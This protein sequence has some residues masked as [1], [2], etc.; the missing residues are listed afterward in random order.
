VAGRAA[1]KPKAKKKVAAKSAVAK[2]KV[3][4]KPR[5]KKTVAGGD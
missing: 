1:A 5:V 3:A 2:K 4:A